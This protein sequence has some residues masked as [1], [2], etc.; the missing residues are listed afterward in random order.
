MTKRTI[1]RKATV[2]LSFIVLTGC[3]SAIPEITVGGLWSKHPICPCQ[4]FYQDE[5]LTS[6]PNSALKSITLADRD[7]LKAIDTAKNYVKKRS[8]NEFFSRINLS[9]VTITYKDSAD[10]FKQ[11][12][13]QPFSK[14]KCGEIKYRVEFSFMPYK[15]AS[16]F[17]EICLNENFELAS[18]LG[19]PK[20]AD[21]DFYNII[22]PQRAAKIALRKQR[23]LLKQADIISLEYDD[24]LESFVWEI[25][26]GYKNIK[27]EKFEFWVVKVHAVTG[28]IVGTVLRYGHRSVHYL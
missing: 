2:I 5:T 18:D 23:R 12:Y 26:G 14:E 9:S 7:A 13:S 24:G 27:T 3:S 16:Y 17:F 22:S 19:L 6:L 21:A 4:S 1:F 10:A 15:E 25:K 20:K 28:R 8:G 11:K